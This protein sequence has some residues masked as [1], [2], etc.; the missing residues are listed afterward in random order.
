MNRKKVMFITLTSYS[1][2]FISE[3][4]ILNETDTAE[5][6]CTVDANPFLESTIEWDLP[7]RTYGNPPSTKQK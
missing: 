3:S 4:L 5:F 6:R 1:I 7:N 2:T